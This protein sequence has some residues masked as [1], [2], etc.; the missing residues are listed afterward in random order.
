MCKQFCVPETTLKEMMYRIHNIA[1]EKNLGI[2]RTIEEISRRFF[3]SNY[4]ELT[5]DYQRLFH[6]PANATSLTLKTKNT[7]TIG[8]DIEVFPRL[9]YADGHFGTFSIVS[10]QVRADSY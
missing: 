3:C 8:F 6:K 4:V 9:A 1:T 10:I 7:T 2:T 5:A